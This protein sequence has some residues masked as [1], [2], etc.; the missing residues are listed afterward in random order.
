MCSSNVL[1]GNIP[2]ADSSPRRKRFNLTMCDEMQEYD[3]GNRASFDQKDRSTSPVGTLVPRV[4][5]RQEITL[6]LDLL[7]FILIVKFIVN[8]YRPQR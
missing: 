3:L 5:F 4:K 2:N 1:V 6:L 8:F 7:K